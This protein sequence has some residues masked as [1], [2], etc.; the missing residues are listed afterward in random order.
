MNSCYTLSIYTHPRDP[1]EELSLVLDV[2]LPT[3]ETVGVLTILGFLS[4]GRHRAQLHSPAP[5]LALASGIW[6]A[7][8][9]VSEEEP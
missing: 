3:V 4:R 6:V 8:V 2:S 9:C 1:G 7:V 5:R